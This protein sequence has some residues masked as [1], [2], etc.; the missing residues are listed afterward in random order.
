MTVFML[1]ESQRNSPF[2]DERFIINNVLNKQKEW[3]IYR[4]LSQTGIK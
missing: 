1:N 3:R 2:F 4:N